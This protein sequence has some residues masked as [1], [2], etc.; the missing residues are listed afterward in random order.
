MNV[1]KLI[2]ANAAVKFVIA[3]LWDFLKDQGAQF[4]AR[5]MA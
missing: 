4:V 2:F 3:M 5:N 1:L